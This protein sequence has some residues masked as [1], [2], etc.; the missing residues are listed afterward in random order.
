MINPL[1]YYSLRSQKY[2]ILDLK[3]CLRKN[4]TIG[5]Q[6]STEMYSGFC[7]TSAWREW[8]TRGWWCKGSMRLL[9]ICLIHPWNP[10]VAKKMD[11][12]YMQTDLMV[13]L[14]FTKLSNGIMCNQ[15]HINF[16]SV[17]DKVYQNKTSKKCGG[18]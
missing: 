11:W 7:R 2:A 14:L 16:G 4:A 3:L 5:V 12:E 9:P 17:A 15:N 10:R 18:Q 13:L 6:A 1:W 8:E